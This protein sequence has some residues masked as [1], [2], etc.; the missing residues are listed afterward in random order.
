MNT[1]AKSELLEFQK[2]IEVELDKTIEELTLELEV[3]DIEL[4]HGK[5]TEEGQ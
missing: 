5:L 4:L 3:A 1:N 2:E